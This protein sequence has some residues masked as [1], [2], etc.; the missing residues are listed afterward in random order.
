MDKT[1]AMMAM[2]GTKLAVFAYHLGANAMLF[3]CFPDD[4]LK[5]V[6][7][8]VDSESGPLPDKAEELYL[9]TRLHLIEYVTN[10]NTD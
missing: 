7:G 9:G 6:D 5:L 10:A 2:A 3:K 4:A 1:V 8:I